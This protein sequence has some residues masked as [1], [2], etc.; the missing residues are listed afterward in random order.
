MRSLAI[1][2][3]LGALLFLCSG[4][5]S[6]RL[7][8]GDHARSLVLDGTRRYYDLHVPR[9]YDGRTAVPLVLD[10]HGQGLGKT[11]QRERSS[12]R[13]LAD[14]KGFIVGY[15]LGLFGD[16]DDAE[17]PHPAGGHV[18]PS[19]NANALC[20]GAA[21]AAGIDDVGFARA[22]VADIAAQANIDRRRV[23]ATGFS[24]GGAFVHRL[25]CDAADVFAAVA[26][27]AFPLLTDPFTTCRPSRSIPVI[28]F[29][30]V[31]DGFAPFEGRGVQLS[32]ADTF[33][34]WRKVNRCGDGSPDRETASGSIDCRTD[35]SCAQGAQ[36]ALCAV[37]GSGHALYA[38]P[39]LPLAEIAW[40][41][42]SQFS[43]PATLASGRRPHES[44]PSAKG[45]RAAA[46][47][48]GRAVEP[49]TPGGPCGFLDP[50]Q[51]NGPCPA[52]RTCVSAA[53]ACACALDALA[54]CLGSGPQCNGACPPGQACRGLGG[55]CACR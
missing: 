23:Y 14:A 45:A 46:S 2:T 55:Y 15:P 24:N 16:P 31:V 10:F 21:S 13:E 39:G 27:M 53:G 44:P 19:W 11:A 43:L 47:R 34:Y 48:S 38:D 26:P 25:G 18:G 8:P 54:P 50:P 17:A 12:F 30:G 49:G 3:L 5:V 4:G 41:F 40:Q 32:A 9:G 42:L 33:A 29:A 51:C 20:C 37:G 28:Y 36:V 52:G 7:T 1:G 22:V 35:T 6:P